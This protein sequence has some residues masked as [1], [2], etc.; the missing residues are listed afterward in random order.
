MERIPLV[1]RSGSRLLHDWIRGES[2]ITSIVGAPTLDDAYVHDRARGGAARSRIVELARRSMRSIEPTEAQNKQ[3]DALA[4]PASVIVTTGQQVGLFGGALYTVLKIA[5]A[6][7]W[8]RVAQQQWNRPVVPVFWLEDNDHD[9]REAATAHLL[10]QDNTIE[11]VMAWDE[12]D[13]RRPVADRTFSAAEIDNIRQ[14][15]TTFNGAFAD[16][17]RSRLEQIYT[18]GASWVDAFLAVL[19]PLLGSWGVVVIRASDVIAT[20]MHLPLVLQDVRHPG[21]TAQRV[22]STTSHLEAAGY[23]GQAQMGDFGF[24]LLDDDGRQRMTSSADRTVHA[25][26]ATWTMAEIEQIAQESPWR[27]S[28]GV[29]MRPIVQDAILP[30]V[31]CILGPSEMAYNAQLHDAYAW[32]GVRRAHPVLRHTA[33]LLD[34][35]TER[36]LST[37]GRTARF[38]MRPWDDILTDVTSTLD[39][40]SIPERNVTAEHIAAFIAPWQ[41]TARS[42]DPSLKASAE[43]AAASI[44]K[45]MEALEGKLRSAL[46]RKHVV[47]IDRHKA[48]ASSIYP[49]GKTQERVLS[50][51]QWFSRIGIVDLDRLVSVVMSMTPTEHVVLGLS[52][53]LQTE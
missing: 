35:K 6:V 20:G 22:A 8:A 24:F 10:K 16:T 19:Q 50:T 31:A 23:H 2:S 39:D 29:L 40:A 1:D 27:F 36:L 7:E 21:V 25:G 37:V 13:P 48:L 43:A 26:S 47:E 12:S 52:D 11:A 14:A 38:Y 9:A 45:T 30:T 4:N 51:T 3:I 42:L 17:E 33:T 49:M 18:E 53:V 15:L 32:F 28:P 44:T 41:E 5:S 46:R 34:A